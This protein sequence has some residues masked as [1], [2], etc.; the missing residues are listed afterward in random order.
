MSTT[1]RPAFYALA[2]GPVR[3][4]ITLLHLPYTAWHVQQ[5][6][7]L[8]IADTREPATETT[9]RSSLVLCPH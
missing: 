1:A 5:K 7:E 2:P 3:D 9:C 6:E 4:W 8:A